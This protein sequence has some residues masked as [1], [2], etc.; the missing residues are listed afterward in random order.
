[1]RIGLVLNSRSA[2]D[3]VD[4]AVRAEAAGFDSVYVVEFFNRNAYARLGA[5]AVATE[6]VQ[7]G[8]G[9]AN[10]FTRSPMLT[11]TAALDLDE[12]SGGRMVLGLGTGLQR[13][14]EEWYS[15]PFGK[16]VTD[17]R[18]LIALLRELFKTR[19]PSFAW[20]GERWQ[21]SI[22]AYHRPGHLREDLPIWLAGVN[23]RMIETA[24]AVADGLVGH[25]IHSRRWHR[26]VTLP[27]LREAEQLAGRAEGAC[28]L[29][30]YVIV[31]IDEDEATAL[32]DAKR[33]IGFS[34][35]TEHYHSVLELHG[36]PEVGAECRKALPAFD[37][38]AM[39]DAIP[40][41]L[42]PEIAVY[43][44]PA[45]AREQL[46]SWS[47][48]CPEVLLYPASIGIP[49]ERVRANLDA[50]LETFAR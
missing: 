15:V 2:R 35:T 12:I 3:D 5:L 50:V 9:I 18:E 10:T 30:P 20:Q 25:P 38:E 27:R 36:V 43:G 14:N 47:E 41:E 46:G 31:A 49:E 33:M 34:F 24:G 16:P 28:P 29:L 48:L 23:R 44:T 21:I 8:S 45:Q 13:M 19:G 11:G 39:A 6:R 1:M 42:V 32:R 4:L 26:E 22:P 7:I 37:T 40:D 17:V